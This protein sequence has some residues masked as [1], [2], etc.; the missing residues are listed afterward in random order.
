MTQRKRYAEGHQNL[1]QIVYVSGHT[2]ESASKERSFTLA[3][4]LGRQ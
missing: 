4:H 2:P 1:T 3:N